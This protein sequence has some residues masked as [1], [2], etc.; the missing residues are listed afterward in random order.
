MDIVDSV[1]ALRAWRAARPDARIAL[2]PTMGALHE[3]HL[4]LVDAARAEADAVVLSVFVNPLQFGPAEDLASYPREMARDGVLAADRG[5]TLLFAPS[6]E[7]MYR[8]DT[9]VRIVPGPAGDRWEGAVRPGHFSGVLTVVAKLLHLVQPTVAWF[10]QK[11]IQ[12]LTLIRAMVASLDVPVTI[13]AGATV[14]DFDGLALSS[15]NR[16]LSSGE[17]AGALAIPR[18]L[19]VATRAWRSGE[20][21]SAVLRH[22][23]G[24]ILGAEGRLSVDYIAVAEPSLLAPVDTAEPGTVLAIAARAGATRLLDNT[25]LKEDDV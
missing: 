9:G 17:R 25:I 21:S 16:H 4:S 1:V 20:R 11:D 18:A 7:E 8:G 14:R 22:L 3:G 13:R 5:V 15:R 2:V 24:E 12:Q 19:Q 23:A 10:G 6:T